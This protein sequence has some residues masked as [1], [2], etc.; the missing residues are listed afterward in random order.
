[1]SSR[2]RS[3]KDLLWVIALSG[4][5]AAVFRLWFGLGA[6]TNL[7]DAYPWGLW[8][9]L[10]MVGGVALSTS[11][12][13]VGF[14]VYVLRLKRF[15]PFMKPA[16][17]IAFLG[18]GCSCAALLLD[19]GLPHRF[20]HP[21]FMWNINSFLFEVFWC[22]MLY[23][24]VTAI[25]LAP[26]IFERLRAQKIAH[27]LHR[28]AFVVV[29]IGISLS[30]LHHSSLGS[31]FL[32][33]PQRLHPLWYTPWLPLLFIV[34]AIGGG[35]MVVVLAKILW[36]RWYD[37]TSV[38]GPNAGQRVP[39]I[40]V[41]N[42]TT[43]ALFSRSPQGPAMPRVRALA[44]IA[45]GVLG[46]YLI[47]QITNLFVHGG[48]NAL[49]AWTWESW[50]FLAELL[51]G[52]A[53]PVLLVALPWS[54]NSPVGIGIA[55]AAAAIGLALN[56]LDVGIIGYVHDTGAV[57]FPTLI[58]WAV[59]LGVIAAAGLVFFFV[60]EN[61]PIFT[62]RPSAAGSESG[63]FRLS[64]GS[65]RQLWSTVLTDSLHRVSLIAVFIIPLA[66]VLMYPPYYGTPGSST[67][68]RPAM[69]VDLE[70]RVLRVDGDGGGVVTVFAH[71]EHQKRLG[72]ST[73]CVKCHH[74]ALPE[75][76]STPC[77][78]CHCRMNESTQ[79]FNHEFHL[80]AVAERDHL[81]GLYP[82][83]FSCIKCH[84]QESPKTASTVKD[85][86]EC[87]RENMLPA[88]LKVEETHLLMATAFREA[89][90]QTCIDCHK[91]KA[92]E[93]NRPHLGDCGT[94]HESL[95]ARPILQPLITQVTM[96]DGP[97]NL[98]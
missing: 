55:A 84:A 74:V 18:Y 45:A 94:C 72:D 76:R 23:F 28:V 81:S 42:G 62:F 70:R 88:G 40:R 60:A 56:R 4:L 11:G 80:K 46:V 10:N 31:L 48:W 63:I 54:R 41:T 26:V 12:F 8:K 61:V 53:L 6:T 64:Y 96:A 13:T 95:R 50:L 90:H 93:V 75:D 16:I 15:E 79:I 27:V 38:F 78:R 92:E 98:Q 30:S 19:I 9:I 82:S 87:H 77:S 44:Q 21:I 89:M 57:Y 33:T 73:S 47:L 67:Q 20:W 29:V 32:V 37:P 5:V 43:M 39:V 83:N 35:M 49:L 22:V 3:L 69:G 24:T 86:L 7:S 66:F 1:M 51:V 52:A 25:E 59:S 97:S 65:L 85:C 34:S 17:L 14:L 68:I 58:E 2:T 36:A 91:E 71:A